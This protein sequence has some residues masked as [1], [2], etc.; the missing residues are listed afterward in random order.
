MKIIHL[1]L[2]KAN[3]DRMN[4]VNKV[5]HSLSQAQKENGAEVAIWGISNTPDQPTYNRAVETVIFQK[6]AF[7]FSVSTP[8]AVAIQNCSTDTV[9]HIHGGFIP[10]FYAVAKCLA[11]RGIEYVFTPHGSYNTVA[12]QKSQWSKKIYMALFENTVLKNA[13]AIHCIGE[14]EKEVL[15]GTAWFKKAVL[16]P[17]GFSGTS[18]ES[19]IGQ[20]R[21]L[22]FG[23]C[24]RLDE[25][26][27]GLDLLIQAFAKFALNNRT[28]S[29]KLIGDGQDREQ[30]EA[31]ANELGCASQVTFTGALF[32]DE[33]WAALSECNVF[34]HPSRNEG[35][36]TA[37]LEAAG[38]GIPCVV[39][40]ESNM[41]GYINQWN[42]GIGMETN[43]VESLVEAME[44]MAQ[45]VRDNA[46][47]PISENAL[48]MVR[49]EF[50]WN[51]IG[52][53][54]QEAYAA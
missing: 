9:F 33:K 11:K 29:L 42:A 12:M 17:N 40:T 50:D 48:A 47:K 49:Q 16:V 8:L 35:L 43:S 32:G 30:L 5:V 14:S 34:F 26:T 38:L 7:R 36:P 4:G 2:G 45:N 10:E 25:H 1:V 22:V 52:L 27:K 46:L 51:N 23:F 3:P 15:R 28:A 37:V 44:A 53:Q 31:M 20:V 19:G 41:A 39:S 54:L 18:V 21:S 13:K 6:Q 24:G